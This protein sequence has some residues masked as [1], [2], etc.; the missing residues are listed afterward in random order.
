MDSPAARRYVPFAIDSTSPSRPVTSSPPKLLPAFEPLSSSPLP[1][2]PKRKHVEDNALPKAEL[3][4]YPTPMPTSSTGVMPSSPTRQARPGLQR[5]LS[6]LSERNPLCAVPSIEVPANGEPVLMGRSSNSS[7]HQLSANRLISRVHIV[8]ECLGWNGAKVHCRGQIYDLAKG[9]TFSSN[10]PSADI[11]LDVQDTRVL[12]AWP[13]AGSRKRSMSAGSDTTWNEESPTRRRVGST[14]GFNSSPPPFAPQSPESPMPQASHA[15]DE[16]FLASDPADLDPPAV[17]V[18]EDGESGDDKAR[19]ALADSQSSRTGCGSAQ[20]G[21]DSQT[22][23]SS[24][25]SDDFSDRDEENDPVVHSFGPFGENILS[26]MQSMSNGNSVS[27]SS[28]HRRRRPLKEA[29]SRSESPDGARSSSDAPRTSS[30]ST[31]R[32]NESPIKNHVINQLAFSRL[33]SMPLSTI[34][35]NLPAELRGGSTDSARSRRV[36]KG[37]MMEEQAAE[38]TARLT[39]DDLQQ[40]LDNLPCVGEITRVGKD[41]SG[42]PLENEYYYVPEMDENQMRRDAVVGGIGGSG[43][44]SVRKAHKQYYWKRPRY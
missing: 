41:A 4:Y 29:R 25:D 10:R 22:S 1:R 19:A 30:E 7:H 9:D 11:M 13:L 16:T 26:R 27:A 33:H 38:S 20:E 35:G 3:K 31:R 43:L 34:L 42:Q 15:N 40:M 23:A 8:I 24:F 2:A 6:A 14:A 28:Q 5:T 12:I 21:K 44:R 18:Y 39:G 17:Q 37:A 36:G 32:V